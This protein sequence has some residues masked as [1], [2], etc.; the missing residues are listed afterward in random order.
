MTCQINLGEG[1][2]I[3]LLDIPSATRWQDVVL[4]RMKWA[5]IA[6]DKQV[7]SESA[8]ALGSSLLGFY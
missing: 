8:E 5:T 1:R 3:T 2:K 6:I 4:G 7:R